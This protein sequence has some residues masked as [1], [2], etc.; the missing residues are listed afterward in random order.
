MIVTNEIAWLFDLENL[1]AAYMNLA[2]QKSCGRRIRRLEQ[3]S[4]VQALSGG[5]KPEQ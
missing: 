5:I 2:S 4:F 3:I 1:T